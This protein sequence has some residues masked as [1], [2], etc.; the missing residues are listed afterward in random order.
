MAWQVSGQMLEVCNCTLLCPCWLD[1]SVQPDQGWCG[2]AILFDVEQ[3]NSDGVDLSGRRVVM[4]GNI[5]G[6]FAG[7]NFTIRFYI[8]ARASEEQRRELEAIFSG[9]K[10]GPMAALGPAVGKLL[11]TAVTEIDLQRNDVITATIGQAGRLQWAPRKDSAGRTTKVEAAEA[12]AVFSVEEGQPAK[13]TGSR[14]SDP[15][16][17]PWEGDSGMI[18]RF[19]WR[20]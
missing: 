9:Q 18:S 4:A 8:D 7:G 3:G 10:G 11:P 6:P 12:M 17:R 13:T 16:M 5:P 2:T 15:E 14:W 20:G 1:L 19:T